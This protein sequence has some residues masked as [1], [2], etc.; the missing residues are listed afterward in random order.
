MYCLSLVFEQYTL[1]LVIR[2]E[3]IQYDSTMHGTSFTRRRHSDRPVMP[4]VSQSIVRY[5]YTA[6]PFVSY[7]LL[8]TAFP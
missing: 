6:D 2:A 8:S 7:R 5:E 3:N 4:Q 1:V